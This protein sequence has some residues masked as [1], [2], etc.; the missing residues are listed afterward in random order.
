MELFLHY[1]PSNENRE[2]FL[3]TIDET[4]AWA[5]GE[6]HRF[7]SLHSTLAYLGEVEEERLPELRRIM[8][9]VASRHAPLH[10]EG[11]SIYLSHDGR[12]YGA[13]GLLYVWKKTPELQAVY[14]D[15]TSELKKNGFMFDD[16]EGNYMPHSTLYMK[17][18]PNEPEKEL[19]PSMP[20]CEDTWDAMI[21]SQV[22]VIDGHVAYYPLCEERFKL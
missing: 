3:K 5:T 18:Y 14:D 7:E 1:S 20:R 22:T 19:L 11:E 13:W 12:V 9:D 17:Y 10:T 21:L 6:P 15:I 2:K 4:R 8:K 16:H